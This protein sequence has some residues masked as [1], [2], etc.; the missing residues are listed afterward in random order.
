MG[1]ILRYINECCNNNNGH[2]V[3]IVCS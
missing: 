1:N 2:F 3:C